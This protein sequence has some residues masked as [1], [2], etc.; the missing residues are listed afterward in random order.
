M[1]WEDFSKKMRE[2]SRVGDDFVKTSVDPD[3]RKDGQKPYTKTSSTPSVPDKAG[4]DDKKKG[5][6]KKKGPPYAT[7]NNF[8]SQTTPPVDLPA[9][10]GAPPQTAPGNPVVLPAAFAN[11]NANFQK[12]AE[13]GKAG[14]CI[15]C[16]VHLK[17]DNKHPTH[18][19]TW[20]KSGMDAVGMK[21]VFRDYGICYSCAKPGHPYNACKN[22]R[23]C[24]LKDAGED[25]E[26]PRTHNRLL[27]TVKKN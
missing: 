17:E 21:T 26:C 22:V 20:A 6:W 4:P 18:K 5:H 19:C 3:K 23:I 7:S 15:P 10:A 1:R 8:S 11:P 27:H 25:A 2:W 12:G 14:K 13:L 9:P 24:K 16:T